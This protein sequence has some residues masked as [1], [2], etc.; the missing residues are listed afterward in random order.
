MIDLPVVGVVSDSCPQCHRA[1]ANLLERFGRFD[2]HLSFILVR[3]EDD[4]EGFVK[5]QERYHL[6]N[7][8]SFCILGDVYSGLFFRA[9]KVQATVRKIREWANTQS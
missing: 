6:N 9:G 3:K 7:P 5:V 2:I 1:M 4:S 8:P